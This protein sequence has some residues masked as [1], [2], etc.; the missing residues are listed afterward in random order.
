M[1]QQCRPLGSEEI[2]GLQIIVLLLIVSGTDK[3]VMFIVTWI[4]VGV[5]FR[6][7]MESFHTEG[8]D[9]LM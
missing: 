6:E 9:G 8:I 2:P 5:T 1:T 4:E 3:I 7:K